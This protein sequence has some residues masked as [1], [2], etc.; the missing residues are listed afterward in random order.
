VRTG[1]SCWSGVG[2]SSTLGSV[3]RQPTSKFLSLVLRHRPDKIGLELDRAGWVDIDELLRALAAHGHG[4][5][6]ADLEDLVADNDKQRFVLDRSTG[7]IR[8]N[9][10]HSIEVDLE[11]PDAEPPAELYHGTPIRNAESISTV[12]LT[13]QAR[14]AVHLSPDVET[15][16]RV[17]ARRGAHVV[18]RVNAEAMYRDGHRFA[19][20][21]NG[22]WLTQSVPPRYLDLLT[23]AAN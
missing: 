2:H 6:R 15:A 19:V 10:G 17:G 9:Q 14:H 12:G 5:T 13:R 4:M 8:A 1:P 23:E 3:K 20:S 21:A 7:R 18:F 16:R 11:L 22:V